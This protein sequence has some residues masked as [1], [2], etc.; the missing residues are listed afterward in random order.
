MDPAITPDSKNRLAMVSLKVGA[1]AAVSFLFSFILA[2]FIESLAEA[3]SLYTFSLYVFYALVAFAMIAPIIAVS[4][5]IMSLV[6]I[7]KQ[8]ESGLGQTIAGILLGLVG[9]TPIILL[10][11]AW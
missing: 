10:I 6:Q 7:K 2:G 8:G 3:S 11:S 5:G 9:F 1:A 4:A